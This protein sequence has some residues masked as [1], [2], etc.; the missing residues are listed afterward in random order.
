MGARSSNC[1]RAFGRHKR[2]GVA[3]A[4]SFD[5]CEC[6]EIQKLDHDWHDK[7]EDSWQ[8]SAG[9]DKDSELFVSA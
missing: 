5:E 4:M 8:K 2:A 9:L 6:D 3:K 1:Q 7:C